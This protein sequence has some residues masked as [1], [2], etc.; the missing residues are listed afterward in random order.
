MQKP[1]SLW[2]DERI[3]QLKELWAAELSAAQI[4]AV[5]GAGISRSA[6]LGK[7]FRLGLSESRPDGRR[8]QKRSRH[9]G[10]NGPVGLA[11]H[12]KC[13]GR[14]KPLSPLPAE[15][16]IT[17]EPLHLAFADL[18]TWHCRWPYGDGPFTFC[19]HS[20]AGDGAYCRNHEKIARRGPTRGQKGGFRVPIGGKAARRKAA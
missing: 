10:R 1:A 19:G 11:L 16:A 18:Q 14:E 12:R 6:I 5:L 20:R 7:V 9:N 17:N 2:T 3:E 13:D 8:S 4:A 15:T